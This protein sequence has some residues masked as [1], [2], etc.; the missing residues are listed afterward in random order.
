MSVQQIQPQQKKPKTMR[1][2]GEVAQA[3]LEH[4]D[5]LLGGGEDKF[6]DTGFTDLDDLA[7]P[8][9]YDGHLIV[10]AGRPAMGKTALAQQ[11]AETIAETK[12]VIFY[13]L[14]MGSFELVQRSVCRRTGIGLPRLQ[15]PKELTSEDWGAITPA[16]CDGI[17]NIN[18]LVDDCARTVTEIAG[19]SKAAAAGLRARGMPDLGLIVVDYLQLMSGSGHGENR[20]VQV[21]Q[22]STALK[23]LAK[24][25]QVPVIAL[26]QLN[27]ALEQRPNKRPTMSDLRES[28]QIE[29][30]ADAI[31]FIYRDEVYDEMTKDKGIAEIIIG[32][33]R[34][35]PSSQTIRLAWLPDRCSFGSLAHNTQALIAPLD[36][37]NKRSWEDTF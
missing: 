22:I 19:K 25:L 6:S 32:K 28:G 27:R 4:I 11:I 35:G 16:V 13:S 37:V 30:D 15:K 8:V 31:L 12:T 14:E 10:I 20:T 1:R 5:D 26:S 34:H 18:L 2:A 17:S 3:W 29:Q 23:N 24:D 36:L 21:G 33:N 9:I 7:G